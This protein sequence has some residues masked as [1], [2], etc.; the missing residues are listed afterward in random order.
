M[1]NRMARLNTP[2]AAARGHLHPRNS[3]CGVAGHQALRNP[4]AAEAGRSP[5][6]LNVRQVRVESQS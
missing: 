4:S 3:R 1:D 2:E 5:A 6:P